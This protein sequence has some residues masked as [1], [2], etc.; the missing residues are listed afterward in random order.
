MSDHS[1]A[2]T[3]EEQF[4]GRLREAI[5]ALRGHQEIYT[6]REVILALDKVLRPRRHVLFGGH[7]PTAYARLMEYYDEL[8]CY[9]DGTVAGEPPDNQDI[10]DDLEEIAIWEPTPVRTKS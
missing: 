5:E 4:P 9:D 8:R 1:L 3:D 2:P 10:V 7:P 6:L